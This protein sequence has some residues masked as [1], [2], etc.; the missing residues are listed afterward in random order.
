M[1][2]REI[3]S[4]D[5][6]LRRANAIKA[7]SVSEP[8]RWLVDAARRDCYREFEKAVTTAELEAARQR[9]LGVQSIEKQVQ[10]IV[11]AGVRAAH[12]LEQQAKKDAQ[13]K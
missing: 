5:E 7:L 3:V 13:K 12:D 2:Q 10:K 1:E 8:F 9:L 6:L 4:P 11:D